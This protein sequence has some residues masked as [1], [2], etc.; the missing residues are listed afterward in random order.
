MPP[1]LDISVIIPFFNA[2]DTLCRCIESVA[3]QTSY[4]REIVIIDDGSDVP[5]DNFVEMLRSIIDVPIKL[6]SQPNRGAAAARNAA[7]QVAT[8]QYAA[9]LDADDIWLPEKLRVQHA[10]MEKHNLRLS[11]H[12]YAFDARVLANQ[13][14]LTAVKTHLIRRNRFIYGNPLFTPTV[15]V[16]RDEFRRFDERFRRVDDYKAWLENFQSGR[17]MMIEA[18]LAAGFK[19]PIGHSGLTGSI[20]TMHLAFIDV[21][22]A[23]LAER[24][25]GYVFYSFARIIELAKLPIRRIVAKAK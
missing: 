13:P 19:P 2:H 6:L 5:I 1:Q 20:D 14:S 17:Y 23:L 16:R 10:L 8:S 15:M 25:I 22:D 4:P 18:V 21:L 9:F 3:R 12:G 11:G 7:L 24:H